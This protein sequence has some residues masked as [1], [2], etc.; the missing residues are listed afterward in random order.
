MTDAAVFAHEAFGEIERGCILSVSETVRRLKS[1]N[2]G[3]S[4]DERQA[5]GR[6]AEVVISRIVAGALKPSEGG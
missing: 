6:A 4:L 1:E 3:W 5:V 2:Q